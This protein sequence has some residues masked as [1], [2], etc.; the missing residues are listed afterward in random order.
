MGLISNPNPVEQRGGCRQHLVQALV[1]ASS[2]PL[3]PSALSPVL[4]ARETGPSVVD[5]TLEVLERV[6]DGE[7]RKAVLGENTT[8]ASSTDDILSFFL[9]IS[10]NS[11]YSLMLFNTEMKER[12][13]KGR[14]AGERGAYSFVA[15]VSRMT[16]DH[17]SIARRFLSVRCGAPSRTL[18]FRQGLQ[19]A[20]VDPSKH[21]TSCSRLV[22]ET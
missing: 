16:I 7:P 17:A 9:R 13:R 6:A 21:L 1:E 19:E 14:R 3:P 5:L 4:R 20:T 18:S 2:G 8:I 11:T 15:C 10:P 22:C 12:V